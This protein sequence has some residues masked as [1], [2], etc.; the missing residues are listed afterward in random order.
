MGFEPIPI[1][2]SIHELAQF[3]FSKTKAKRIAQRTEP[4]R[5][6]TPFI[7]AMEGRGTTVI[8]EMDDPREKGIKVKN[9]N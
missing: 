1:F 2:A 9:E 4:F 5:C 3:L 7:Q 6:A 8:W